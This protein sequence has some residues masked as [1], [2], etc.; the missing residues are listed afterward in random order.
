MEARTVVY[1][2]C[3]YKIG[4]ELC[5][6]VGWPATLS[7]G[8]K[9]SKLNKP[10]I[11]VLAVVTG[12]FVLLSYTGC[13]VGV[14]R[15]NKLIIWISVA[16]VGVITCC[17][18]IGNIF[19]IVL[20]N[21]T[22]VTGKDAIIAFLATYDVYLLICNGL[23]IAAC[24]AYAKFLG[25]REMGGGAL[26]DIAHSAPLTTGAARSDTATATTAA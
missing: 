12:I 22:E 24:V 9:S 14:N 18:L 16:S 5:Y 17:K 13:I 3:G 25:E 7:K 11:L 10:E 6:L 19:L 1:M 15:E 21:S 2:M 26:P 20:V 8:D 23:I 4:L